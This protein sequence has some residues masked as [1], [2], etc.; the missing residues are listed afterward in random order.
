M[1]IRYRLSPPSI[2]EDSAEIGKTHEIKLAEIDKTYKINL[3]EIDKT[4]EINLAEIGK[5]N[6]INSAEIGKTNEINLAEIGK[7]NEIN[8]AEIDKYIILY[9]KSTSMGKDTIFFKRKMY[10]RM[11][12]WKNERNG[13]SAL[14]IQGAR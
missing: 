4:N 13:D 7:T 11:L 3:A 2:P 5:T 10:E 14:L 9:C 1:P 12:K 6:E 8:L